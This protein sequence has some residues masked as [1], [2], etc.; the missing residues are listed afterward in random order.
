MW[1]LLIF[2]VVPLIEIGL[3]IQVGGWIGLWPTLAIILAMAF[4]GAWLLRR[5]G[6][7]AFL[8]LRQSI[9]DLRDPSESMAH[10]ALI[11]FA[12]V[13]L[14]TPGFFTDAMGLALLI[15]PVRSLAIRAIG[16]RFRIVQM[17]GAAQGRA[18]NPEG[19]V[20]DAEYTELDGKPLGGPPSGW[21]RH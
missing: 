13:L 21:T 19:D 6:A 9:A 3:F 2:I 17:G 15:R 11:L 10:G 14:I 16:Q 5:E 4:L 18:S 1:L 8:D 20:I 7:R 12:G